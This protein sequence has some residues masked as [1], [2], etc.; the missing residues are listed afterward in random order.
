[1]IFFL[2]TFFNLI[3]G[4]LYLAIIGYPFLKLLLPK[5]I[6]EEYGHML[7]YPVGYLMLCLGGFALS[8]GAGIGTPLAATIISSILG[9]LTILILIR[10]RTTIFELS[11]RIR[12]GLF[13]TLTIT[14]PMF[15]IMLWPFFIHGSDTYLGAVN[16]DYFAGFIDNY[17]LLQ[18]HS[19]G[20]FTKGTDTHFP[21]DYLA[22]S[23]S[24]S[25]RFASGLVA[26]SL[27]TLFGMNTREAL[28]VSIP[29]F[30]ACL[31]ITMY[32]FSRVVFN[33]N[34]RVS[35]LVAWL[36]CFSGPITLSYLYF[37]LGQNS[38][39]AAIPLILGIG[40]LTITR[41]DIKML[42]LSSFLVNALF[43]TYLGMLPYALAPL[44]ILTLYMLATKTLS[45]NNFVKLLFFALLISFIMNF[46]ML[47]EIF[48]MVSGWSNVIG[49]TLQG[50]YFL[51]FLT[52]MFFPLFLGLTVYPP[53]SSWLGLLLENYSFHLSVIVPFL[54]LSFL[55]YSLLKWRRNN[56]D[57]R[58]Q[59]VTSIFV[60]LGCM[61]IWSIC[62]TDYFFYQRMLLISLDVVHYYTLIIF[63]ITI[64]IIFFI[65]FSMYRWILENKKEQTRLV[66]ILSAIIIYS[67]VWWIYTFERQYGYAVFKMASWLQFIIIPFIAY[68]IS[69]KI[70]IGNSLINF[71]ISRGLIFCGF[72]YVATNLNTTIE[73][74]YKG[75]GK[76]ITNGYIVNNFEMSGNRNYF[77]IDEAISKHVKKNETVGLS[78]VD[79]IQNFWVAYYL[80][81]HPISILSHENIPGDDENL[82]DILTNMVVDYYGN[83]KEANNVFFHGATDDYYLT[84]NKGHTNDDIIVKNFSKPPLWKNETFRLFNAKE[85][86]D[87]IFTGRGYYRTEYLE[88]AKPY[89]W[90]K[91]MRWTAE[92]GEI[93][94]LNPSKIGRSHRIQFDAI[95]GIEHYSDARNIELWVNK[96][97][98]DEFKITSAGRYISK[99]FIPKEKVNKLVIKIKEKVGTRKRFIPLWNVDIPTDYRQLNVALSNISIKP[100]DQPFKRKH[101]NSP[102]NGLD[103]MNCSISFDGIQID[104]WIG[105]KAKI[106]LNVSKIKNLSNFKLEGFAPGNL[107]F[108]FPMYVDF[109]INGQNIKRE[110]K[111]PGPFQIEIPISNESAKPVLEIEIL[112]SQ[113]KL[114][115]EQFD[116]RRKLITQ[117]IKLNV[118]N[119]K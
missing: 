66:I 45:I 10:Q 33:F 79:S 48:A 63:S 44:G 96:T 101:C 9:F 92:G 49:Q 11:N 77:E 43:V 69:I 46:G 65:L 18:G 26:I 21:F 2:E 80:R 61:F 95:V 42:V 114:M 74:G 67:V 99:P 27:E 23:I 37:Y 88:E 40:Y 8:G 17:F 60:I 19:V 22:G 84:W 68:G 72:I 47:K 34:K 112:P 39:L 119:L 12:L 70:V 62:N 24:S 59:I 31:P 115:K 35:K 97:K 113:F 30:L 85:N 3:I 15:I 103:I 118:I 94:Y 58:F 54:L 110:I 7:I 14:G 20:E 109:M 83:V 75:M 13:E 25:G 90:P 52:E 16:P 1:M 6:Y 107:D 78:F 106:K 55:L 57:I 108:V 56:V 104:Q 91:T 53:T 4:F 51:D 82:P 5:L 89:W 102:L 41:V 64:L 116:A 87:M 81:K 36:T 32:F 29:L 93:Y 76:D 73:Y 117:S 111:R 71:L 100:E 105:E 38:G 50:Q 28:T 86:P 98:F